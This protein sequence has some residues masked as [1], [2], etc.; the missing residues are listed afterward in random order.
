MEK[1][2]PCPSVAPFQY[3]GPHLKLDFKCL[4]SGVLEYLGYWI[5]EDEVQPLADKIMATH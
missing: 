2:Y 4:K 1:A 3:R 5:T